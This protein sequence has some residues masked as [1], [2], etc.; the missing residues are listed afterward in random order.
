MAVKFEKHS[1]R[2]PQ[3]R[4]EYKVYRELQN[5]P[6]FGRVRSN[7]AAAI[8]P[9]GDGRVFGHCRCKHAKVS[10]YIVLIRSSI[11]L[12]IMI[13][14]TPHYPNGGEAVILYRRFFM[15]GTFLLLF[16]F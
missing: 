10:L 9:V 7:V 3:L 4:H 11:V 13:A 6:G 14:S 2:C 5:C 12:G 15:Q 16:S 1:A 8:G